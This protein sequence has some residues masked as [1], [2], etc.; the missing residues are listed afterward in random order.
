[1]LVGWVGCW[2]V[3]WCPL[4]KQAIHIISLD[5]I[6]Y[7]ASK[8]GCW[9]ILCWPVVGEFGLK[10]KYI[11]ARV[12]FCDYYLG[13]EG[14]PVTVKQIWETDK[15]PDTHCYMENAV[16]AYK[17]Q[18]NIYISVILELIGKVTA[19]IHQPN[20]QQ[21]TSTFLAGSRMEL[22][23]E[24]VEP[25]RVMPYPLIIYQ[26]QK[27]IPSISTPLHVSAVS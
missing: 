20:N 7:D 23:R 10:R 18:T 25:S 1:M 15:R 21:C 3:G 14:I 13:C 5:D 26:H 12:T 4:P 16:H 27:V 19:Q 11:L 9:I 2:L 22:P 24:C 8:V 17:T 6:T